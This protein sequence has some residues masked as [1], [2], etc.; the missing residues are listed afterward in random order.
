M[1]VDAS[2]RIQMVSSHFECFASVL[3]VKQFFL[4]SP[5]LSSEDF[6]F[7]LEVGFCVLS[8]LVLSC[9]QK[10]LSL[11]TEISDSSWNS[12]EKLRYLERSPLFFQF[13]N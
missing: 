3:F 4:F 2:G 13:S 9:N 8:L 12:S 6:K 5:N 11:L 10:I 1:P 7:K